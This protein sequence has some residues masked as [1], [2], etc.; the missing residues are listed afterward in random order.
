VL[1]AAFSFFRDLDVFM[2]VTGAEPDSS[3]LARNPKLPSPHQPLPRYPRASA[4]AHA[5]CLEATPFKLNSY[6]KSAAFAGLSYELSIPACGCGV[7]VDASGDRIARD[8]A[9]C[10]CPPPLRQNELVPF[11]LNREIVRG[12]GADAA[13]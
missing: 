5:S 11:A 7:N 13:H 3:H 4:L 12:R 6:P 8:D 1:S 2:G 9:G 10:G